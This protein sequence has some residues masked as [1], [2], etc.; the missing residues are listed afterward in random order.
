MGYN[1]QEYMRNL[2]WLFLMLCMAS[3]SSY[4]LANTV[5]I[6]VTETELAEKKGNVFT[7][8]YFVD[9]KNMCINTSVE[10]DSAMLI[11]PVVTSYGTYTNK[12]NLS[13]GVELE[14]SLV[15]DYGFKEEKKGVI[16]KDA[17]YLFETDSIA[18]VY[19]KMSNLKLK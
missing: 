14:L 17:M 7:T 18:R 1:R 3:C 5:W 8:L 11:P 10:Q 15:D 9:D 4:K 13:K 16:T 6:N 12:G 2:L 19:K